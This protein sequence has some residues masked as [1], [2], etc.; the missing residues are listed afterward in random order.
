MQFG[1]EFGGLQGIFLYNRPVG[2]G[3][4]RGNTDQ[5]K[6]C[7]RGSPEHFL[8]RGPLSIWYSFPLITNKKLIQECHKFT[9]WLQLI[10]T[11]A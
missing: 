2:L 3:S 4:I 11:H 5:I 10:D 1:W 6:A 7:L 8:G 9:C